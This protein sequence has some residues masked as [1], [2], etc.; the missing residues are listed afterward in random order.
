MQTI[1][2]YLTVYSIIFT[3]RMKFNLVTQ[4][5]KKNKKHC[6]KFLKSICLYH[7]LPRQQLPFE[8]AK[9]TWF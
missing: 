3:Q 4:S 1:P 9:F 6:D 2:K 8:L 7:V 5:M